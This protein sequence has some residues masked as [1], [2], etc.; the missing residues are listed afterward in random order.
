[1]GEL[2]VMAGKKRL[3]II[4]TRCEKV[5]A[6]GR[7]PAGCGTIG[8][9]CRRKVRGGVAQDTGQQR[10]TNIRSRRAERDGDRELVPIAV[11]ARVGRILSGFAAQL[12]IRLSTFRFIAR[13]PTEP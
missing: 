4:P 6:A 9:P 2:N 8:L 3:R 11:L 12:T 13:L 10:V 5:S 1:M 7:L